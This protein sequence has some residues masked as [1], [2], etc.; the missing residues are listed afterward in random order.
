[1]SLGQEYFDRALV[2]AS[3]AVQAAEGGSGKDEVSQSVR[4]KNERRSNRAKEG[5]AGRRESS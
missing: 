1:M 5:I 2:F 4:E 3:A